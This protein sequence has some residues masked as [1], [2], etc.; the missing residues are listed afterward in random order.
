VAF[1]DII[2]QPEIKLYA[3]NGT[4]V[5]RGDLKKFHDKLLTLTCSR[6]ADEIWAKE[7][8]S[9]S[10]DL[11][12]PE[13]KKFSSKPAPSSA[14]QSTGDFSIHYLDL[15]RIC[16]WYCDY[17]QQRPNFPR[18]WSNPQHQFLNQPQKNL[19]SNLAALHHRPQRMFQKVPKYSFH[20]ASTR[21]H[22]YRVCSWKTPRKT[23]N[24]FRPVRPNFTQHQISTI[25]H[26]FRLKA[27]QNLSLS[28]LRL[29]I[30]GKQNLRVW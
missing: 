5:R 24:F 6:D 7:L 10:G 29:T 11:S 13:I 23:Y 15:S 9:S 20:K 26:Q 25:L 14:L 17:L 30:I 3:G 28:I 4:I 27:S 19:K 21:Q 16:Y 1:G 8:S 12:K 2:Y 18:N 22:S